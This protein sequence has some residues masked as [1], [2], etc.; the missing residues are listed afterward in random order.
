MVVEQYDT[1]IDESDTASNGVNAVTAV[2]LDD[3]SRYRQEMTKCIDR[4]H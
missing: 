2:A 1:H 4:R 3:R